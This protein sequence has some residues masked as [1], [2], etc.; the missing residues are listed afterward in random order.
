MQSYVE[1]AFKY[2]P[3][4]TKLIDVMNEKDVRM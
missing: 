4:L 2:K 1:S 3:G